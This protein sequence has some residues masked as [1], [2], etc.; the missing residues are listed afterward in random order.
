MKEIIETEV[1]VDNPNK[2]GY[3]KLERRKSF[4]EVFNE[5][6][7]AVKDENEFSELDY[8]LLDH[9]IRHGKYK[10]A[11]FPK[12]YK[13]ICYA[14]EGANEGHYIHVD[15]LTEEGLVNF[16]TAKTFLGI[17]HALKLSNIL[18]KAFYR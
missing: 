17:E 11:L 8:F 16:I 9:E 4:L 5:V 10:K 7:N 6:I 3:L 1:W 12:V 14:N 2:E 18:T 15:I 13:F